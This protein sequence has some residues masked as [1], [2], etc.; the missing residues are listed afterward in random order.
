MLDHPSQSPGFDSNDGIPLGIEITAPSGG[1]DGNRIALEVSAF[2]TQ[3]RLDDESKE[4]GQSRTGSEAVAGHHL[5]ER[6]AD[7]RSG[8]LLASIVFRNGSESPLARP[9]LAC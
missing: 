5:L 4:S 1:L 8:W 2:T 3:R 9:R 6:S 7:F